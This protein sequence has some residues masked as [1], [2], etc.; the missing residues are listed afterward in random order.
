VVCLS[1]MSQ[2]RSQNRHI[3]GGPVIQTEQVPSTLDFRWIEI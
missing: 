3:S 1:S 2:W